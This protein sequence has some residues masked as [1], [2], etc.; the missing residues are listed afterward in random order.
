MIEK[1]NEEQPQ[2]GDSLESL[3]FTNSA[4]ANQ[5]ARKAESNWICLS[6]YMDQAHKD[7]LLDTVKRK[8]EIAYN[9]LQCRKPEEHMAIH[10]F[11]FAQTINEAF[12]ICVK[13]EP[14]I[15]N[16]WNLE[17]IGKNQ[18]GQPTGN[19]ARL[20]YVP[21]KPDDELLAAVKKELGEI[22]EER[23]QKGLI[24]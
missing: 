3:L 7:E 4:Q 19:P 8:A 24:K 10:T 23:K 12:E 17:K 20:L 18:K 6:E 11:Y 5:I 16:K 21:R 9:W 2:D 14:K 15:N 22:Y 1:Q 13:C